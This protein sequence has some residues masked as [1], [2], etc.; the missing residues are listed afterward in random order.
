M[1][2]A[3]S[4]AIAQRPSNINAA[5]SDRRDEQYTSNT[6]PI[7]PLQEQR[8]AQPIVRFESAEVALSGY[9]NAQTITLRDSP[10]ANAPVSAVLHLP[11]SEYVEILGATRDY[12]RVRF[13]AVH[14]PPDDKNRESNR[15]GW[16][17]WGEVVPN[18]S[19]IV[20][21]AATG[22]LVSRLPLH[23]IDAGVSVTFSPDNSRAV[24]YTDGYAY[25]VETEN[26]TLKRSLR[27]QFDASSSLAATFFYGSTDNTLYAAL[28]AS[29]HSAR[30]GVN[31]LNILRVSGAHELMPAPLITELSSG[32]VVAPDGR[33]GF[34]LHSAN[35]EADEMLVDV[36]DLQGMRVTNTLTLRG[37]NLPTNASGFVTSADGRE[38]YANL[39]PSREVI[40]VIDTST[41]QLL[42]EISTG[43][44]KERA[45]Y[46]SQQE[47]VGDSLLFRVWEGDG[48]EE[49]SHSVWLDGGKANKA[50]S[51]IDYAV[52]ADGVRLAVNDSGTRLFKLDS[53]NRIRE[54]YWID[55]PDVR[56]DQGNAEALGVY[57][58]IASPDGKRI[59]LI[60]GTIH[61]C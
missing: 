28:N 51:G 5:G 2:T 19:A 59:I 35:A 6:E 38:L 46:L 42:R 40:N 53:D 47:L 9:T 55:R 37:E 57:K 54:K 8:N 44:L 7:A 36:L 1:V 27:A 31:M 18:V 49:V 25:D 21:D 41:G 22:T 14:A 29:G 39:I 20:L 52:E 58:F 12:L 61:S 3:C 17:A 24:F 60:V 56:L 50:Q 48:D 11:N 16:V 26:Y 10:Q 32:F 30:P 34:I 23:S 43:A 13:L 45:Q 33:T 15:E 4:N